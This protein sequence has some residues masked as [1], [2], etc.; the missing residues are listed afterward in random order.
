MI[1]MCHSRGNLAITH[2]FCR[3]GAMIM[4]ILLHP[5]SRGY[6]KLTSKDPAEP[7]VIQPNYLAHPKDMETL[8]KGMKFAHKLA[9]AKTMRDHGIKAWLP[10]KL[11]KLLE[12]GN[13]TCD[14]DICRHAKLRRV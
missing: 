3:D 13:Q 8:V 2:T 9:R 4:P 12:L 11:L 14:H 7:P 5:M 6:I 1:M 10:G